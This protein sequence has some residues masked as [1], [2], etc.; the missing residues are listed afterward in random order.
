MGQNSPALLG[1]NSI[2]EP[3]LFA[4]FEVGGVEPQI[5]PFAFQWPVKEGVHPF[6]DVLAQLANRALADAA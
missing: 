1:Q 5:R 6:I 4:L 2:A 3:P